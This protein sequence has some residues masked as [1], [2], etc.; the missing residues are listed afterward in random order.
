MATSPPS[1]PRTAPAPRSAQTR[2]RRKLRWA[3]QPRKPNAP[4]VS[5]LKWDRYKPRILSLYL[6]QNYTVKQTRDILA[7]EGLDVTYVQVQFV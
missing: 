3:E 5:E 2:T 7:N 6:D 1:L 4:Q